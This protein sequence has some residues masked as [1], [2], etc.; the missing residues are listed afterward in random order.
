MKLYSYVVHHDTGYA[1][2]PD[3][4]VCTLCRCKFRDHPGKPRN[5]GELVKKGDWVVGTGGVDLCKSAGHGKIVYAMRVDAM[6]TR[7]EYNARFGKK[8]RAS[9]PRLKGFDDSE[10]F[11]LISQHFYYFGRNAIRIPG[12][13]CSLE[14][15]GPGFRCRDFD[16]AYIGRFVQWLEAGYKPGKYGEPCRRPAGKP[17]GSKT[18]K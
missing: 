1:P 15:S 17:I 7:G 8:R 12:K 5:L 14:K 13:F 2:N 3:F 9:E 4:S 18:C 11:A 10:R 16:D 6:L